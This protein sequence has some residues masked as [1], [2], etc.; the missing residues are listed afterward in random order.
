MIG[1]YCPTGAGVAEHLDWDAHVHGHHEATILGQVDIITGTLGKAFGCSG[2]YIA[3]RSTLVDMIR[4]Y[5]PGFIFT[6]SLSPAIMAGTNE[7]IKLL[8]AD[9]HRRNLQHEYTRSV[10]DGLVEKGLPVMANCACAVWRCKACEESERHP[11]V[12]LRDIYPTYQLP[13]RTPGAGEAACYPN[14]RAYEGNAKGT[15]L[16]ARLCL[17]AAGAEKGA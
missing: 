4:S 9:L 5:A 1:M 11:T 10:N 13:Y 17:G 3:G 15:F 8:Q 16:C 2:G 14:T 7:A 6:T 12:H